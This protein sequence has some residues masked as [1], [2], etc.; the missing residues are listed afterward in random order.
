MGVHRN[1]KLNPSQQ[2]FVKGWKSVFPVIYFHNF[3]F[4]GCTFPK[5][6]RRGFYLVIENAAKKSILF[7]NVSFIWGLLFLEPQ[8]PNTM[9]RQR[10]PTSSKKKGVHDSGK[11]SENKRDTLQL[12]MDFHHIVNFG[13]PGGWHGGG[14]SSKNVEVSC[15]RGTTKLH[16]IISGHETHYM[17]LK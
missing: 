3:D 9:V 1:K 6:R 17:E 15:H 10:L 8:Y 11:K 16:Q 7:R 12:H 14:R 2:I 5:K 4:V 13:K